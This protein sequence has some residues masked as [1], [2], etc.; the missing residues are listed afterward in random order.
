[1]KRLI[2]LILL[3]FG[4]ALAIVIGQRMST[5]AMAVVIG[6][7]VGV[8]ASVPT[9][10]LLIALLRRERQSYRQEMPRDM[11][12]GAYPPPQP[13]Q[14]NLI[15]LDPSQF[16]SMRNGQMHT[17][18]PPPEYSPDGGMRRLRVVGSDDEWNGREW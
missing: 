7:A 15:V 18:L 6:V 11:P 4:V 8:A 2:P 14:P 10:L 5:D 13:Q 3:G 17:P 16:A 9:S 1:M 12:Y